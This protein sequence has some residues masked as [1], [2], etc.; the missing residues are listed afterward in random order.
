[1]NLNTDGVLGYSNNGMGGNIAAGCMVYAFN[2][3]P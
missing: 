2:A 1:M 3:D